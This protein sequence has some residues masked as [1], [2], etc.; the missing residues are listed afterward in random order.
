ES[1]IRKYDL[2]PRQDTLGASRGNYIS[3]PCFGE[4]RQFIGEEPDL[5]NAWSSP[6]CL[7]G[8]R[9]APERMPVPLGADRR[10]A[11]DGRG[12]LKPCIEKVTRD[13]VQEGKRNETALRVLCEAGPGG[14]DAFASACVPAIEPREVNALGKRGSPYDFG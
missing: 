8:V 2:F 6:S 14:L 5:E 12:P 4:S 1:K 11:Q 10:Y 9:F 3:L 13:G 7:E